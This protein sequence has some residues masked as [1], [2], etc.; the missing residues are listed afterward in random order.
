MNNYTVYIHTSPSGKKYIGITS[1]IPELRWSN[2][3][4]YP[5]NQY[6]KN[7]IKKYGWQNIKHE[8]LFSGLTKEEAEQKEIELISEHKSTQM[9]YGYNL[10]PGGNISKM[11]E[12]TKN[13]MKIA[14]T[15]K[16]PS[17]DTRL[18][19]SLSKKGELNPMYTGGRKLK[20]LKTKEEISKILSIACKGIK[21][22]MYG[23]NHTEKTKKLMSINKS[24]KI[25]MYDFNGCIIGEY[26]GS[27]YLSEHFNV[28]LATIS[29]WTTNGV[30]TKYG[31]IL[32]Y[33]N[34]GNER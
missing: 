20:P 11:T 10:R 24:K 34:E 7:A 1:M 2:G 21:N 26:L 31:F 3:N 9:E 25:I 8:I 32:R 15:G 29:T 22:G 28:S 14:H 16:K 13:K 18:K 17:D 30:K 12:E 4:G 5:T 6:F 19:L 33:E 27:K 23:K